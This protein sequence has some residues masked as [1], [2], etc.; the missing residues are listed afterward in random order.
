MKLAFL[1]IEKRKY[2]N[3]LLKKIFLCYN[4]QIKQWDVIDNVEEHNGVNTQK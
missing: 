4:L 3:K 2:F 1:Y